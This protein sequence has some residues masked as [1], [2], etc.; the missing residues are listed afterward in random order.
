MNTCLS[1]VDNPINM[2]SLSYVPLT[3][4][5]GE[6]RKDILRSNL[7]FS[8]R[9]HRLIRLLNEDGPVGTFF[10]ATGMVSQPK[11]MGIIYRFWFKNGWNAD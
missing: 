6:L 3:T 2:S 4:T 5:E 11:R 9:P 7:F 1:L 8:L 10:D